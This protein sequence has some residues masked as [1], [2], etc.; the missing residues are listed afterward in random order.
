M[1]WSNPKIVSRIAA[2]AERIAVHS[3]IVANVGSAFHAL[4]VSKRSFLDFPS[5]FVGVLLNFGFSLGV[6]TLDSKVKYLRLK[7]IDRG[8]ETEDKQQR[9]RVF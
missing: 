2:I 7:S 6:F 9:S 4:S 5:Q 1:S 8:V 3:I